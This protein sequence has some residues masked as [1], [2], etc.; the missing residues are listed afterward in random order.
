MG[1]S[2]EDCDRLQGWLAG[3]KITAN[4]SFKRCVERMLNRLFPAGNWGEAFR[5]CGGLPEGH[6]FNNEGWPACRR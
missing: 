2:Q 1:K 4:D 3:Y 6:S 5:Q